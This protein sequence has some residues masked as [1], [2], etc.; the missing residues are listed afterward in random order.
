M[1]TLLNHGCP[2]SAL[3]GKGRSAL[4]LALLHGHEQTA[5]AMLRSAGEAETLAAL[6]HLIVPARR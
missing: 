3:D 2:L 1:L 5:F 4:A 6:R